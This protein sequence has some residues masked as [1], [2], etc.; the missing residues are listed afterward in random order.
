MGI[1]YVA[2]FYMIYLLASRV[3]NTPLL[4]KIGLLSANF[5][6]K[7]MMLWK[8]VCHCCRNIGIFEWHRSIKVWPIHDLSWPPEC[9][10]NNNIDATQ[11]SVFYIS[12]HYIDKFGFKY[13]ELWVTHI[14]LYMSD[15]KAGTWGSL[16]RGLI[17]IQSY[18]SS[19]QLDISLF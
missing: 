9:S 8:Y 1:D 13:D 5:S 6:L 7:S 17:I 15:R 2:T 4:V 12:V 10:A 19:F 18:Q 14:D 3:N 11:Y 16:G